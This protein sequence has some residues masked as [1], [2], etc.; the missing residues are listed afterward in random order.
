MSKNILVKVLNEKIV[1][2]QEHLGKVPELSLEHQQ[3][4]IA[5]LELAKAAV[6]TLQDA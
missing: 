6:M 4:V 2:E 5:G 3:G 1:W